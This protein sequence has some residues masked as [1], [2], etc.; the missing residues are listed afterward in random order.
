MERNRESAGVPV[1]AIGQDSH[2]FAAGNPSTETRILKLGGVEVP[3]HRPLEGNSDAD[4]VLHALTNAVSGLTGVNILGP[5]ADRMCADGIVDSAAYLAEAL[6]FLE[7]RLLHVS[8]S[9]EAAVPRMMPLFPAMR[10]R[11]AGLCGIDPGCVGLTATSGEGLT[12]CGRGEGISVLCV[13]TALLRPGLPPP[14]LP[15]S[16]DPPVS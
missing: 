16:A 7:G 10:D 11:I 9:I 8:I 4:V 13:A 3:G 1:T 6:R 2:R 5:T 12:A 15:P 14:G